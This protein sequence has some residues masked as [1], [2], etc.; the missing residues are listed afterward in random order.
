MLYVRSQNWSCSA[1]GPGQHS[2]S[3]SADICFSERQHFVEKFHI[4]CTLQSRTVIKTGSMQVM[5]MTEF[6]NVK[7]PGSPVNHL[8]S[9]WGTMIMLLKVREYCEG[10]PDPL[11]TMETLNRIHCLQGRRD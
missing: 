2:F 6:W 8:Y 5:K 3:Q 4:G 10:D 9:K 1:R 7:R 11:R